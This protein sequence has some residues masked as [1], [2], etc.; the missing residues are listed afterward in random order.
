VTNSFFMSTED[1]KRT[2]DR[3]I[4]VMNDITGAMIYAL[5]DPSIQAFLPPPLKLAKTPMFIMYVSNIGAPL[6][7]EPYREAG[8]GVMTALTDARG[9]EHD[10]LYYFSLLLNGKGAQ[11]AAF[12]G[13]EQNG[14]PKKFADSIVLQRSRRQ[15]NFYVERKGVRLMEAQMELGRYNDPAFSNGLENLDPY[16][17]IE[18]EAAVFTHRYKTADGRGFFDMEV[19]LYDS[20]TLYFQ[21]EPAYAKVILRSS[22]NDPW[23]EIKIAKVLG[24][25]WY[26][27]NNWVEGVSKVYSYPD[28]EALQI[29]RYLYAGRFDVL[30]DR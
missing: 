7:A 28:S 26:R 30:P 16:Q 17:G 2:L 15:A 23:G 24:A 1:I 25:A 21:Y 6:F 20:K 11:N 27:S 12:T 13:R 10:G 9:R 3:D 29:M 18:E 19:D 8:I 22:E 14:L 4:A 5:A